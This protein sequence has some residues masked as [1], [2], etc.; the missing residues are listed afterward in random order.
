MIKNNLFVQFLK[1]CILEMCHFISGHWE[2]IP[3]A[4]LKIYCIYLCSRK[5]SQLA[6][7]EWSEKP[8]GKQAC[9]SLPF[10]GAL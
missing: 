2:R 9:S 1:L 6:G 3:S 4:S 8:H 5:I 10:L 7:C